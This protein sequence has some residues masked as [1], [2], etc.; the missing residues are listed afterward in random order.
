MTRRGVN[1]CLICDNEDYGKKGGTVCRV[2]RG[3]VKDYDDLAAKIECGQSLV[4][5]R[6]FPCVSGSR[7]SIDYGGEN[8]RGKLEKA[9]R[10]TRVAFPVAPRGKSAGDVIRSEHM[11]SDLAFDDA[12]VFIVPRGFAH[13]YA[14]IEALIGPALEEAELKG[15]RQ[16]A[17]LLT[18]LAGGEI[19]LDDFDKR[20]ER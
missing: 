9:L 16:G 19:T 14:D 4:R 2:C 11:G 1:P 15:K 5:L 7:D 10:S 17:R 20:K 12:G 13:A 6:R 3:K 18:E 8:M